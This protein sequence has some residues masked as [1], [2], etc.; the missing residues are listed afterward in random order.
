MSL[1]QIFAA[2]VT[3]TTVILTRSS[4]KGKN[5]R[6]SPGSPKTR[7][8]RGIALAALLSLALTGCHSAYI[9][10]TVSNHTAAPLS[11]VQVE[12]P[13]ASFGIQTIAPGAD[14]HYRFKIL[15]SG[16]MKITWTDAAEHERKSTGP[17]LTE[18]TEGPLTITIAPDGV[19]WQPPP[20]AR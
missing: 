11:I 3:P 4:P 10:A 13:S 9:S 19:H 18:G 1:Q 2:P 14:F 20:A 16:Q 6:T 17:T 5:P 12:Y 15:G 8:N 7:L